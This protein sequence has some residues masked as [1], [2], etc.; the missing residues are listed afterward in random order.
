MGCASGSS[1]GNVGIGRIIFETLDANGVDDG[2]V[3]AGTN[4]QE[5]VRQ[6]RARDDGV[7]FAVADFPQFLAINR[8]VAGYEAAAGGNDHWLFRF[9]LDEEWGESATA[10]AT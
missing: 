2:V 7:A 10:K 8:V 5:T 1:P 9:G 4:E 6:D 3:E